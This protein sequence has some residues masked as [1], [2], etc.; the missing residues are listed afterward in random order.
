MGHTR[1][2][3]TATLRPSV[4]PHLRGAYS[5]VP[6]A[7][8]TEF[9][10]SPHTWGIRSAGFRSSRQRRFIPTYVGHTS[11]SSVSV[12]SIS[13]SSPHTWG[14]HWAPPGKPAPPR[15]IPT[16]VGHTT[17]S[18][19]PNGRRAVHPHI[20][21]AY[22]RRRFA[23]SKS[24]G[25]SPYTWGIRSAGFRSSRQRRFIPTYVGH[26]MNSSRTIRKSL[27]VHPHI[28]GAYGRRS[29][30]QRTVIWF[31]P[32]YVGHT[33][34]PHIH[35]ILPAVHP[36]IR[37][38]YVSIIQRQV[39]LYGSSPHTWGIQPLPPLAGQ[40]QRFIPTYVGH[41]LDRRKK[42]GWF[43]PLLL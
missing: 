39:S 5:R 29:G 33:I 13:G 15:F 27:P 43:Q 42:N 2:L 21:G 4:H 34:S 22:A 3:R 12:I 20:R 41:T 16:Y 25:S 7:R 11:C 6:V 35:N 8:V 37:G 14:I 32:T 17:L 10:S 24:R 28:R 40:Q 18:K 19:A 36:H 9:G 38:A 26:T 31:I 23:S 1:F 30:R